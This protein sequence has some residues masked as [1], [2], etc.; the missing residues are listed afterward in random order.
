MKCELWKRDPSP[1][2]TATCIAQ[3]WR[4]ERLDDPSKRTVTSQWLQ[5]S[6]R[7]KPTPWPVQPTWPFLSP[8]PSEFGYI[9]GPLSASPELPG[10][11]AFGSLPWKPAETSSPPPRKSRA[12]GPRAEGH[13]RMLLT[14]GFRVLK[15]LPVTSPG[16]AALTCCS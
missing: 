2:Y 3:S 11:P 4:H 12:W 16:S 10:L 1:L 9:P 8:A 15:G 6:E 7:Q 5:D 14:Q 13:G